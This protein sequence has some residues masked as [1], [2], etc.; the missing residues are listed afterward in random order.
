[1]KK[2]LILSICLLFICYGLFAQELRSPDSHLSLNFKLNDKGEAV[3]NLSYKNEL[4]IG[5]SGM[6]F[7]I[8]SYSWGFN[9][10][11]TVLLL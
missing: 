8:T 11:Q 7:G 3:Y 5:D 9:I 10:K 4:I 6:G 1:M 2:N